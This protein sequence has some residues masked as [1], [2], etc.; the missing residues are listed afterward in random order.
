MS[1][2]S[3]G[4]QRADPGQP[5]GGSSPESRGDGGDLGG[6]NATT[7]GGNRQGGGNRSSAA[8]SGR[9]ATPRTRATPLTTPCG[10]HSNL[11]RGNCSATLMG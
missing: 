7:G 3:G 1:G 11:A 4:D 5:G 2:I 10:R 8:P 9:L 6:N